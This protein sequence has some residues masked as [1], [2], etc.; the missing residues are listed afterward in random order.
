ME[1]IFGLQVGV[2][3]SERR[4]LQW[5]IIW[6]SISAFFQ[7]VRTKRKISFS[8]SMLN[9]SHWP[10]FIPLRP[11]PTWKFFLFLSSCFFTRKHHTEAKAKCIAIGSSPIHSKSF[12][13][14]VLNDDYAPTKMH[15]QRISGKT[16]EQIFSGDVQEKS[17][18]SFWLFFIYSSSSSFLF[19]I[20]WWKICFP[21]FD[22]LFQCCFMQL[23]LFWERRKKKITHEVWNEIEIF[24]LRGIS[25]VFISQNDQR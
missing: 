15:F 7:G 11:P 21:A 25:K 23:W 5:S 2:R 18:K 22:F 20:V 3:V 16:W 4:M 13:L 10:T 24:I 12:V 14:C 8:Y 1:N 19:A 17:E 9:I 6:I